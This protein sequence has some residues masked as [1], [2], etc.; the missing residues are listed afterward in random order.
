[1]NLKDLTLRFLK[2]NIPQFTKKGEIFTCPQCDKVSALINSNNY[3]EC[4][5]CSYRDDLAGI[6]VML[7][8]SYCN[9]A[10]DVIID[11]ISTKYNVISDKKV[12]DTLNFFLSSGFDL[13]PIA[14]LDKNPFEIEWTTKQHRDKEEWIE[15]IDL[16]LN[17]GIK[18]GK[19]SN[20][21][22]L[23]FDNGE[24]PEEIL[25]IKGNPLIQKTS[26]GYHYI[27]K[28]CDLPSSKIKEY[29]L[30][31]LNDGKSAV[32]FP[33]KVRRRDEN[34]NPVLDKKG[35]EVIDERKFITDLKIEEMPKEL[36]SFIKS[37][38]DTKY[39]DDLS[40]SSTPLALQDGFNID[41]LSS[42]GR[43]NNLLHLGGILSKQLNSQDV[44]FAL[45]VLNS[46]ICNPPLPQREVFTIAKSLNKYLKRDEKDLAVQILKY[47]NVVEFANSK[48]I[49][50]ALGF[51]KE[52]IDKA[53]ALLVK[54]LKLLKKGRN[55]SVIKKGNWKT[56]LSSSFNG[57]DFKMP[58][59]DD[60]AN[61]CYGDMI[62]LGSKSKFGKT[63]I[64]CNLLY[65]F[66]KQGKKPYYISLE[67]GSRFTK[68]AAKLGM[69]EGD[70]YW[71]FI[72]D[73]TK[74]Q[75]EENAITILDWLMIADKANTDSVMQHFVEQLHK[76]NGILIVFVQLKED[77]S[78][79]APNMIKQFPAFSARYLYIDETGS[80]GN[81]IVDAIRD[82]KKHVKGGLITCEYDFDT[83]ILKRS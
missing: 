33:S 42:G 2:D 18:T 77:G 15:W 79:F 63:T 65:E 32:C 34:H 80:K 9:E 36:Y 69:K 40:I 41:L 74:I 4:S 26:R 58:F 30:D 31:I 57:I 76:T 6:S 83:K 51:P 20:I 60:V 11:K 17:I 14:K 22:I 49:K 46:K 1:M 62:L 50:D 13:T 53:L 67:S 54:E 43:N 61:F 75:L 23:D 48:E 21:T 10:K 59:F 39:S 56:D 3:I 27:Y 37:K 64:S 70:F 7:G 5:A 44:E 38:I 73:P 29:G 45:Q 68:T 8:L 71:D 78:Y 66:V 24:V 35:N 16:G 28:Y 47:L 82:P 52:D 19:V 12:D 25:N 72:P 81:W 55:F